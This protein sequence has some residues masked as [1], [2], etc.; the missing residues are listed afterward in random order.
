MSRLNQ[1]K[2]TDDKIPID[3]RFLDEYLCSLQ[4]ISAP[5]YANFVNYL[6]CGILPPE[7]SF[8]QKKKFM[9]DVKHYFWDEP[10]LFKLGVDEIYRR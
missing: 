4:E 2:E 6:A 5:W 1:S 7:Q 10:Y 3:D 9:A 8:Q